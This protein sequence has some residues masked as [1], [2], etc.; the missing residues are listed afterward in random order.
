MP[1]V[2]KN[3]GLTSLCLQRISGYGYYYVGVSKFY[4]G[5]K[6]NL[7]SAVTKTPSQSM[8]VTYTLTEAAP[9]E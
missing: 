5:T 7:Q 9:N 3:N 8:I 1:M 4:L 6:Y 2:I